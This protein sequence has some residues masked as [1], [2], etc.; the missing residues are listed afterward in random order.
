MKAFVLTSSDPQ[1]LRGFESLIHLI[2]SHKTRSMKVEVQINLRVCIVCMAHMYIYI[3]VLYIY[4]FTLYIYMNITCMYTYIYIY[5]CIY[6]FKMGINLLYFWGLSS[7]IRILNKNNRV[8]C[9]GS[10]VIK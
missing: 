1:E 4:I 8:V 3:Y 9:V 7:G 2:V 10:H 6:F 5:I